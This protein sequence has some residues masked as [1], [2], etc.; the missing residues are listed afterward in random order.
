[1]ENASAMSLPNKLLAPPSRCGL[2]THTSGCAMT[3]ARSSGLMLS[4][5]MI[6]ANVLRM[7]AAAEG[8]SGK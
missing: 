5:L 4:R 8:E 6:W 2:R 1:V 3:E 7:Q